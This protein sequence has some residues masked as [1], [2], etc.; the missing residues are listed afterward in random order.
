MR[1]EH[2]CVSR[3][4]DHEAITAPDAPGGWRGLRD[5]RSQG[6]NFLEKENTS[7]RQKMCFPTLDDG[8]HPVE[9]TR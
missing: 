4:K 8:R 6:D 5:A 3:T 2:F 7:G 1:I 9:A